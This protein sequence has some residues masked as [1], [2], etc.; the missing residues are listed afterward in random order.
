M[1]DSSLLYLLGMLM[2][3]LAETHQK[4]LVI[5]LKEKKN[6]QKFWPKKINNKVSNRRLFASWTLDNRFIK[7]L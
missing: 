2:K 1:F 3:V 7:G 6:N 5:Q 4:A